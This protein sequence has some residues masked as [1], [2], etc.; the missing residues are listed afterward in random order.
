MEGI[1]AEGLFGTFSANPL[2][3]RACNITLN[4]ILTEE[5][6]KKV[7]EIGKRCYLDIKIL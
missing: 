3:I 5:Q 4:E 2:S 7:T 6:Y 1:G